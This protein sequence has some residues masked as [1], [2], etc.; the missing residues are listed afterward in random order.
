LKRAYIARVG[1]EK[2]AISAGILNFF[3]SADDKFIMK[4]F[5]MIALL[6]STFVFAFS[7]ETPVNRDRRDEK[8]AGVDR[9]RGWDDDKKDAF[10]KDLNSKSAEEVAKK[11]P[12]FDKDEVENIKDR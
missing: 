5:L 3:G 7:P 4:T 8:F 6:S 10:Y 1:A 2:E 11:Y 9:L 12:D